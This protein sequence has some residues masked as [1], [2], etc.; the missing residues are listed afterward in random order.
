MWDFSKFDSGVVVHLPPS[1]YCMRR[2]WHI[3]YRCSYAPL[4]CLPPLPPAHA[5]KGSII[6][7]ECVA[8]AVQLQVYQLQ[9]SGPHYIVIKEM[10]QTE[11]H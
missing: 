9:Q 8:A 7:D 1:L 3:P 10:A 11:F 5:V 4:S 2:S 6:D